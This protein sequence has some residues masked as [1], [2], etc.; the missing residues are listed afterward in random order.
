MPCLGCAPALAS[1]LPCLGL[2]NVPALAR[3]FNL[4]ATAQ[5]GFQDALDDFCKS[6]SCQRT[7]DVTITALRK[8]LRVGFPQAEA[9]CVNAALTRIVN[10][11][12]AACP[13]FQQ[14]LPAFI[15]ALSRNAEFFQGVGDLLACLLGPEAA[16]KVQAGINECLLQLAMQVLGMFCS[17]ATGCQ[18]PPI[19]AP[20]GTPTN[21]ADGPKNRDVPRC[22]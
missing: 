12:A 13:T 10:G 15:V 4:D 1:C 6:L 16:L 3:R 5:Q 7:Q 20:P 9:D 22:S 11:V 21:P 8:S 19:V 2:A 17:Q 14:G 18:C